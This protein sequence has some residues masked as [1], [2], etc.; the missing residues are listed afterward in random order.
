MEKQPIKAAKA[1]KVVSVFRKA[2]FNL[3]VEYLCLV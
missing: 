3:V 1:R 2:D